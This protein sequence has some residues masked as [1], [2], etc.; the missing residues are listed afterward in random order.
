L[1][2]TPECFANDSFS[3]P[4]TG[5]LATVARGLLRL[6]LD[7]QE[8]ATV[9]AR[10]VREHPSAFNRRSAAYGV[11]EAL[12]EALP[13][14]ARR[15]LESVLA[16]QLATDDPEMFAAIAPTLAKASPDQVLARCK[17]LLRHTSSEVRVGVTLALQEMQDPKARALPLAH[18]SREP[19]LRSAV[20][21]VAYL[22]RDVPASFRADIGKRALADDSPSLRLEDTALLR[23]LD[24]STARGLAEAALVDEPD[25]LVRRQLLAEMAP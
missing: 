23:D 17:E 10:F 1:L 25:P 4:V 20:Q 19:W 8:A 11:C 12:E 21:I 5:S 24:T 22:G 13:A 18:V 2:G 16:E 6:G 3:N 7:Q 15:T 9:L 14:S